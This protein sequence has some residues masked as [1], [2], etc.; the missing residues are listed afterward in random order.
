MALPGAIQQRQQGI[1]MHSQWGV[2]APGWHTPATA[3]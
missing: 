2:G 3:P 1:A